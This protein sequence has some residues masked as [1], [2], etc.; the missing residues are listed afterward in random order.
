MAERI[1]FDRQTSR[2]VQFLEVARTG[3][4]H[5]AARVLNL[6][7]SALTKSLQAL[8]RGLGVTLFDRSPAGTTLT[9]HG[10]ALLPHAR[11]IEAELRAAGQALEEVR[12]GRAGLLRVAAGPVWLGHI[13]P[14]VAARLRHGPGHGLLSCVQVR[15]PDPVA[16][17]MDNEFDVLCSIVDARLQADLAFVMTPKA[18]FGMCLLMAADHPLAAATGAEALSRATGFPFVLFEQNWTMNRKLADHLAGLGLPQPAVA[19]R[20]DSVLS[21]LNMIRETDCIG[22]IAAPIARFVDMAGLVATPLEVPALRM[23]VGLMHRKAIASLGLFRRFEAEVDRVLEETGLA[24][25][26]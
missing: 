12:L 26:R 13:L 14:K 5:A 8:E 9:P 24:M 15:A 23:E 17:L 10:L 1:Q 3:N 21:I 19:M 25:A 7:Q 4:I 18:R 22:F 2:I 11:A 6:T 16:Q 20:T